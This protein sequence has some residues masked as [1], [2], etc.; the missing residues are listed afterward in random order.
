MTKVYVIGYLKGDIESI[1]IAANIPENTEIVCI[2]S[3]EEIPIEER[4][5]PGLKQVGI[6]QL[7]LCEN[8]PNPI[9]WEKPNKKIK[10]YERPY[11]FHK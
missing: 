2:S 5:N 4:L 11:K 3:V 10:G 1:R 7:T 6:H 9:H 8:T